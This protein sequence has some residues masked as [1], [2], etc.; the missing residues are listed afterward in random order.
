MAND[1]AT[2]DEQQ[3]LTF[4]MGQDQ[5]SLSIRQVKEIIAY[6][7]VMKIPMLPHYIKGVINLRGH[8]VPVIDLSLRFGK[9]NTQIGKLTCIIIIEVARG[10]QV[11]ELG[12][13]VDAVNEVISLASDNIE[14]RPEFGDDVNV[15]FID[16]MGRVDDKFVIMLN[17]SR[18]LNVKDLDVLDKA[19]QAGKTMMN[20]PSGSQAAA[21]E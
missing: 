7:D 20:N 8:V 3:Y 6:T 1:T 10:D 2:A 5:Y 9:E 17:V 15:E 18:L 16:G 13:M 14:D 19:A 12:I 21:S 4:L 11:R